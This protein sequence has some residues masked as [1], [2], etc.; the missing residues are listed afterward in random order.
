MHSIP[1]AYSL[2]GA[3]RLQRRYTDNSGSLHYIVLGDCT[4]DQTIYFVATLRE[5]RRLIAAGYEL[6]TRWSEQP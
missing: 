6:E 2:E 4:E 5:A 1:T 3:R